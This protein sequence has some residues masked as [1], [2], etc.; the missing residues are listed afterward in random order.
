MKIEIGIVTVPAAAAPSVCDLLCQS[1][2][3]A[4]WNFAPARV[5]RAAG[6]SLKKTKTLGS[7]RSR[8]SPA[9]TSRQRR[10]LQA[11]AEGNMKLT[12]C[13]GSSCHLKGSRQIVEEFQKTH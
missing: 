11:T 8:C 10:R 5:T 6:R 12:V 4:V 9:S 7:P 2:I 1:G 13:I 3:R